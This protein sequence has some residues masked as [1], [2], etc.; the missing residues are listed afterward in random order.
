MAYY[1]LDVLTSLRNIAIIAIISYMS[2]I[3][4]LLLIWMDDLTPIYRWGKLLSMTF[5]FF[6]LIII[7]IPHEDTLKCM[8]NVSHCEI[9]EK[10]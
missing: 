1:W 4:I 6:L 7:F 3:P 8:F 5:G 10:K 2:A 9:S